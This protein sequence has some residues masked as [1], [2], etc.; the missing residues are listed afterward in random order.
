MYTHFQDQYRYGQT[1]L[2]R[3]DP[4]TKVVLTLLFVLTVSLTPFGAFG[5]YITLF[6]FLMVATLWAHIEPAY[7]LKRSLIALP[8]ALAAVTLPFTVPGNP[9]FTLPILGGVTISDAGTVRFISI[10]IKSWLSLQMAIIL[11]TVTAFP[12][13]LWSLRALRIPPPLIAIV[14]LLYR[15]LFV[16]FEEAQRLM[17]ARAARSASKDGMSSGGSLVWRGQVAGRMAGSLMLRSFERS[18]RIYNAMLARGYRGQL[19]SME[20]SHIGPTDLL[21]TAVTMIFLLLILLLA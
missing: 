10:L 18:E 17:R 4:R 2:H 15:Y 8:F 21:V 3:L 16:L 12:A 5:A 19:L 20:H 6:A 14:S 7:L 9:L 1:L 11:V 13:I